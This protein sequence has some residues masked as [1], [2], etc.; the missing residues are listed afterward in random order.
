[1][2]G[3][4]NT[5]LYLIGLFCTKNKKNCDFIKVFRIQMTHY[6]KALE[7]KLAPYLPLF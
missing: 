5:R 2:V 6:D 4:V 7:G 1:M 3:F